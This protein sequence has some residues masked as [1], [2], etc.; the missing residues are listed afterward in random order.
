MPEHIYDIN[1]TK[2]DKVGEMIANTFW[3]DEISAQ[4]RVVHDEDKTWTE[5]KRRVDNDDLYDVAELDMIRDPETKT[6]HLEFQLNIRKRYDDKQIAKWLLVACLAQAK[7]TFFQDMIKIQIKDTTRASRR[8]NTCAASKEELKCPSLQTETQKH[9]NIFPIMLNPATKFNEMEN[10][11]ILTLTGFLTVTMNV[12]GG[13]QEKQ[14][15]PETPTTPRMI[16]KKK[17]AMPDTPRKPKVQKN[18]YTP[19]DY[20]DD[21]FP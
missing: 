3:G 13:V 18:S 19:M 5:R 14:E 12:L 8:L 9:N 17:R 10:D 2:G 16:Q 7:E 15:A 11:D 1:N 20:L 6:I 4:L 21:E